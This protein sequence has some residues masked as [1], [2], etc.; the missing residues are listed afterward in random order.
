MPW[1]SNEPEIIQEIDPKLRDDL[2]TKWLAEK[3]LLDAHKE[4]EL[5]SRKMVSDYLFP[6]PTKGTNRYK[7][8]GGYAIKLVFGYNYRLG[9]EEAIDPKTN[10]KIPVAEQVNKL[11]DLIEALG[12]RGAMI[13]ER[14][15]KWTPALVDKEYL[16]LD[17]ENEVDK[18]IKFLI[19]QMLTITP[20]TPQLTFEEP[21]K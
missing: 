1:P 21:K 13:S 19:D 18:A 11:Q 16:A 10:A 7:L 12:E 17:P 8:N 4:Q 20:A 14:I 15:I 6:S 9:N 3:R 2:I 5:I